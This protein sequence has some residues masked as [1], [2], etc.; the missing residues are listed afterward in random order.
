MGVNDPKFL[1]IVDSN[2]TVNNFNKGVNDPN[3]TWK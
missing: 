3:F 1:L 2:G